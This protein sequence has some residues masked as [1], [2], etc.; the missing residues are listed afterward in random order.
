[1]G[2]PEFTVETVLLFHDER[3]GTFHIG[4]FFH[5]AGLMPFE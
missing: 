3:V 2:R 4:R 5:E 1:M